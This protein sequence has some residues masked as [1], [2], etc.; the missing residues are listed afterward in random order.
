VVVL[1]RGREEAAWAQTTRLPFFFIF[2]YC[3]F[4]IFFFLFSS[5]NFKLK[6][7]FMSKFSNSNINEQTEHQ[8]DA[9]IQ[10]ISHMHER[11][12][13]IQIKEIA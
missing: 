5:F 1:G 12:K 8:H 2:F 4:L 6:L 7:E 13:F 9:K 10:F 11:K 3:L